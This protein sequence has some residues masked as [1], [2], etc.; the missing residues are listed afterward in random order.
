MKLLAVLGLLALG[1]QAA[2]NSHDSW[3]GWNGKCLTSA[4]A[5]SI[6][7]RSIIYLMHTDVAAAVAAGNSLF[8][9]DITEFG[10]SIN[11]LRGDAVSFLLSDRQFKYNACTITCTLDFVI[12][13]WLNLVDS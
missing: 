5:Q 7:D 4:Q 2:P 11:S 10:D 3:G 12:A 1:A 6:V 13:T 9:D 8:A